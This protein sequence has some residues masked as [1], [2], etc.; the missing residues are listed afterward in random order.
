MFDEGEG[1]EGGV[2]GDGRSE[3]VELR[4]IDIG[5]EVEARV[6]LEDVFGIADG[7]GA[8]A[9]GSAG[10]LLVL[11]SGCFVFRRLGYLDLVHGC[12]A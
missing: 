3:G 2:G 7:R 11:E 5:V 6:L 1:G 10:E 9:V 12:T 8:V 4:D